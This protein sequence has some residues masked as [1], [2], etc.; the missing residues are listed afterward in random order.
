[1]RRE[2]APRVYEMKAKTGGALGCAGLW[3]WRSD[4]GT[5]SVDGEEK[6]MRILIIARN[7]TMT[8]GRTV[9]MLASLAGACSPIALCTVV[10]AW[11][12]CTG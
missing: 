7:A 12:S 6:L 10:Q 3:R 1:M 5:A 4:S 8:V 2:A 9:A 11:S